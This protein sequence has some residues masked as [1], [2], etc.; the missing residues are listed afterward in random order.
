MI[1]PYFSVDLDI[2]SH[3]VDI[4]FDKFSAMNRI[5][6]YSCISTRRNP[7]D[8]Q[9]SMARLV[10]CGIGLNRE[11]FQCQSSQPLHEINKNIEAAEKWIIA[12][13]WELAE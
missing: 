9:Y 5:A 8:E 7:V 6:R 11:F 4:S 10:G 13:L 3:V 1:I 2:H 12:R